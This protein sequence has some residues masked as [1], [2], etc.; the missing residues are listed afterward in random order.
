[1]PYNARIAEAIKHFDTGHG[2]LAVGQSDSPSS[3]YHNP[4]LFPGLFPWLFPY[5]LGGFEN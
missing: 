4:S 2:M 3:M 1:M 5:G